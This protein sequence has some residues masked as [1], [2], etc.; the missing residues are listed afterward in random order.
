VQ[1]PPACVLD[2]QG[3]RQLVQVGRNATTF[4]GFEFVNGRF[5]VASCLSESSLLC[6][7]GGAVEMQNG[8]SL[9]VAYDVFKNDSA[10]RWAP[11][12]AAGRGGAAASWLASCGCCSILTRARQQNLGGALFANSS[13]GAPGF[14]NADG[15]LFVGNTA[16]GGG[17]VSQGGAIRTYH[18]NV[19]ATSSTFTNNTAIS[20]YGGSI[21][22]NSGTVNL[23]RSVFTHDVAVRLRW[24]MPLLFGA[25]CAV[26]RGF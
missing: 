8:G 19:N 11:W 13:I 10:V 24:D 7:R 16:A 18:V 17:F 5:V 25:C 22:A 21:E 15:A 12:G 4:A 14:L 26:A 1:S 6:G 23:D 9:T 20:G 2:G 3:V